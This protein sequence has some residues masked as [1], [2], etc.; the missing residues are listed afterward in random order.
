MGMRE[1]HGL[2]GRLRITLHD[3]D[4]RVVGE[5]RVD[6]LITSAGRALLGRL[7]TGGAQLDV[8][9]VRIAIGTGT[10]EPSVTDTALAA[11]V[12]AAAATAAPPQADGTQMK[13]VVTA[14]IPGSGVEQAQPVTEA[15]IELT[16]AGGGTVLYNRVVFP[17]INRTRS[18]DMTLS[19]EVLF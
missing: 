11:R 4:G 15:G 9:Q 16:P 1:R 12:A 2:A 19:W 5:R 3:P 10:A 14:T 17:P 6:N 7:L 8:T 18:L 13:V